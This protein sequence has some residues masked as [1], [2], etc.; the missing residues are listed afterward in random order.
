MRLGILRACVVI[1]EHSMKLRFFL[2]LL[3]FLSCAI[4]VAG[5]TNIPPKPISVEMIN[6]TTPDKSN[7]R[8]SKLIINVSNKIPPSNAFGGEN[9]FT[10]VEF[11]HIPNWIRNNLEDI[12][13]L[14]CNI[15]PHT[16]LNI[17]VTKLYTTVY[18]NTQVATLELRSQIYNHG[19]PSVIRK[20]RSENACD[21]WFTIDDRRMLLNCFNKSIKLII[22]QIRK[23]IC[24][25]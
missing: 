1:K 15:P 6:S 3:Y 8:A 14:N 23:D 21:S 19:H 9:G 24:T 7:E 20:Y 13:I 5:C 11:K 22:P 10:T 12:E 4:S 25:L 18:S 2:T 16:V 17:S